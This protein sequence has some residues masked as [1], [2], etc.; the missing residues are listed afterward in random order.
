MYI[1]N[2][3]QW[4]R[5]CDRKY[6]RDDHVCLCFYS[7]VRVCVWKCWVCHVWG[8]LRG[9]PCAYA[10]ADVV[11]VWRLCSSQVCHDKK[12]DKMY[13]SCGCICCCCCCWGLDSGF[14]VLCLLWFVWNI[15][16][17]LGLCICKLYRCSHSLSLYCMGVGGGGTVSCSISRLPNWSMRVLN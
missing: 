2:I 13:D 16:I 5:A 12:D 1:K 15:T 9:V 17:C 3:T 10:N 4:A 8:G 7:G 14:S 11:K 6:F